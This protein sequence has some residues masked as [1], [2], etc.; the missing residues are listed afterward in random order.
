MNALQLFLLGRKLSKLG[1]AAIRG[2]AAGELH[3]SLLLVLQDIFTHKDSSIGEIAGRTGLPQSYVSSTVKQ[4]RARAVLDTAADPEDGRCT[5]VRVSGTFSRRLAFLGMARVE[6]VVA[7]ALPGC[8]PEEVSAV[9]ANLDS[10]CRCFG[11]QG[12]GGRSA[13]PERSAA[14]QSERSPA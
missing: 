13:R 7:G 11:I 14:K 9:L 6:E 10:L 12:Y 5:L 3:P 8:E 4:L 1:Q 2:S